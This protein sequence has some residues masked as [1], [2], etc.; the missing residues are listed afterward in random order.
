RTEIGGGSLAVPN[1]GIVDGLAF[2]PD[3]RVLASS[4]HD[5]HLRIW[6]ARTG[7]LVRAW[8][9]GQREGWSI[10]FTPDG[11]GLLSTGSDGSLRM[12]DPGTGQEVGRWQG[13][14]GWA[15]SVGCSADGRMAVTSGMD[16]TALVWDLRPAPQPLPAGGVSALWEALG[17]GGAAAN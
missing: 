5:D 2:S 1:K 8:P 3:G 13:H 4:H 14:M 7:A 9:T 17:A 11:L 16:N 6:N 12:W 15:L 10:A